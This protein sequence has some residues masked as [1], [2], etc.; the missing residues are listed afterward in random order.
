[1]WFSGSFGQEF[2]TTD[3]ERLKIIQFGVWNRAPGPDFV[4][5][6]IQFLDRPG[7]PIQLGAIELDFYLED[8]ELH[9]HGTNRSFDAVVLHLFF[10]R[11]QT[12][13]TFFTR[14]ARHRQISQVRL[15]P[16]S[17]SKLASTNSTGNG[18]VTK[19]NQVYPLSLVHPGR[20]LPP[21]RRL[22]IDHIR[23]VLDNAARHRLETKYRRWQQLVQSVGVDQ[24]LFQSLA[25]ALGYHQNQLPL[26]LLAQRLPIQF[27]LPNH[28]RLTKHFS[29]AVI[30]HL[31]GLAG[32]LD[33]NR[34]SAGLALKIEETAEDD[35]VLSLRH[36]WATKAS[37]WRRL[38]LDRQIWR[39][40][41]IRPLNNAQ[42][43]IAALAQVIMHWP[44][45]R[46]LLQASAQSVHL[47]VSALLQQLP[48]PFWEHHYT[49]RSEG[50]EDRCAL[51]GKSRILE[52]LSNIFFPRLVHDSNEAWGEYQAQRAVLTNRRVEIAA[53]RL[54]GPPSDTEARELR[55]QCVRTI[56]AQQGLIQIDQ[57]LCSR[58]ASDCTRCAFP[59]RI[60][61]MSKDPIN[62]PAI[63]T[64]EAFAVL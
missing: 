28:I 15:T 18:F 7:S 53:T 45:V 21:L 41:G 10:E 1:M 47:E 2:V 12:E 62:D 57:E 39:V 58:D 16:P 5:T 44:E 60:H 19:I 11:R 50:F 14:S 46:A 37:E 6:A 29:H 26:T 42:R 3:G 34:R 52:M 56:A 55:R 13:R 4:R 51:I 43:R 40:N 32:F 35:Y 33:Q 49:I 23:A 48:D 36:Y 24:A 63:S 30:A 8:W 27:W 59:E 54:F 9:G 22:S 64:T 25:A 17:V 20:C 61:G 31:L 38:K